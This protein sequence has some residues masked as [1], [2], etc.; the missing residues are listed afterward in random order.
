MAAI[1]SALPK[2]WAILKVEEDTYPP[3]WPKGKG[4]AVYLHLPQQQLGGG[5]VRTAS[6]VYIMPADYDDG[7]THASPVQIP[8]AALILTTSAA[9]VYVWGNETPFSAIGWPTLK[10]DILKAISE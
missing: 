7:G 2:G 9:K 4:K 3:Y 1:K 8:T 6:M 10:D 5:N